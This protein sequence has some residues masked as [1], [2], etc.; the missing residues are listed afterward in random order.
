MSDTSARGTQSGRRSW[1]LTGAL[2]CVAITAGLWLLLSAGRDEPDDID[3]ADWKAAAARSVTGPP[4]VIWEKTYGGSKIDAARAVRRLADGGYA[5]AARTRSR[6]AGK[7]DIWLLRLNRRGKR[8]WQK[9]F[10]HSG[11]DWATGLAVMGDGGFALAG[12]MEKGT[13]SNIAARIIR[14]DA[15]GKVQWQKV[16]GGI[17]LDGVTSIL[18]LP[19]GGVLAAGSIS[20][21]GSGSY[22]AWLL[23]FDAKGEL[24]MEKYFGGKAEDSAF[25]AVALKNGYALAGSTSSKGAGDGDMWL[26]RLDDKGKMLWDR[27]YGGQ[28]YDV[29]NVLIAAKDGGFLLAGHSASGEKPLPWVV[30]VDESGKTLWTR[31]IPMKYEGW[32]NAAARLADGGFI[33]A[34]LAKNSADGDENGWLARLDAKGKVLWV[35]VVAHRKDDNFLS[36]VPMP[37]GGFIAAGFTNSKGA[38]DGDV[39]LVRFGYP[40]PAKR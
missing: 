5:I 8:L 1:V 35:K 15:A 33:L 19:D 30:R 3:S 26:V 21:K 25:A 34:G 20:S 10:G 13:P 14:T 9:T 22:D 16:I 2:V 4:K 6:G 37:D 29:A 39:W 28:K 27:T 24:L 40:K 36:V 32:A 11:K 31:R 17:R 23:R 7:D 38:G 18:A 12:S